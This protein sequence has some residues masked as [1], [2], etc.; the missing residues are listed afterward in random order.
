MTTLWEELSSSNMFSNYLPMLDSMPESPRWRRRSFYF[1]SSP[2]CGGHGFYMT[3]L[4]F[5]PSL[6]NRTGEVLVPLQCHRKYSNGFELISL[7]GTEGHNDLA[8]A[9]HP[10]LLLSFSSLHLSAPLKVFECDVLSPDL[11]L[12]SLKSVR[13]QLRCHHFCTAF[14]DNPI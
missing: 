12:V 10:L 4:N 6:R 2:C 7:C 14:C 9:H 13:L 3:L 1:I 11:T 8:P 5:S